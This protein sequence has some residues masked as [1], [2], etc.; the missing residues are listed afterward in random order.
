MK[1]EKNEIFEDEFAKK[2][3]FIAPEELLEEIKPF[4]EDYFVGEVSLT[5][6]GLNYILPN[7]QK[8]ILTA[9]TY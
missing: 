9:Q 6:Q 3:A 8:I 5:K 1:N 7:G 4:L 2:E